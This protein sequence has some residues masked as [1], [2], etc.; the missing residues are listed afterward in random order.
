MCGLAGYL[1]LSNSQF[2]TQEHLLHAMAQALEHRGPNGYRVWTSAAHGIGLMYRRLSIVDLSQ[3]AFQPMFTHDGSVVVCCNGEIYNH[4]ALRKELEQLGYT[5]FS[6]SDIET[7]LYAYQEWGIDFLKR[8]E[9]MFSIVLLDIKKNEFYVVRDH[10]GIKPLYFSMQSDIFSFAS[11]IKALWHLPW[12]TKKIS[13]RSLSHYLTFLATPAPMTFFEGIYKLPAGFYAKIDAQR[14][15]TFCEWYTPLAATKI[16]QNMLTSE[17]ALIHELRSLL[18]A[19]IQKM[20]MADV[21]LGVFLSGGVDSSLNVALMA[22]FTDKVK[23]F[24]V[25]FADGPEYNE[26]H[27]AR[28]VAQLYNTEHHELIINE[29][30]AFGFFQK[31][32]FHQDEPLG[33]CVCVPLYFVSKLLKDAGVTVVQVGEGSDEL[34]CGYSSYIPYVTLEK[35]RALSQKVVPSFARQG[36]YQAAKMLVPHKHNRLDTLYNWATKKE[37]FWGGNVV[38]SE[39]WK[40]DFFYTHAQEIMY[41]DPVIAQIYP[42]FRQENSSHSPIAYH[43]HKLHSLNPEADFLKRMIYVELKHR[44]PELLLMRVDKMTMATSVEARVPFLDH[45][46]VEFAL[47]IPQHFKY[48]NGVTKYILKKAAEGILPNDIIYR[49]KMGFAAPTTRWFKQGTHFSTYFNDLLHSKSAQWEQFFDVDKIEKM[50]LQ[51]RTTNVDYSYQLWALQNFM[52]FY[53]NQ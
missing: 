42:D 32:I 18:R 29:A 23:T 38:F 41:I 26:A 7:L 36:V 52:G 46:L 30:D 10:I 11:E 35:S 2:T 31:M 1:N 16:P 43:A 27:W 53:A 28:K 15:V 45:A 37:F 13:S 51:T 17:Q 44:L 9:G 22:E 14:T 20:M 25:A 12:L 40:H 5:Y 6:Q 39:H 8:L 34:F 47:Q 24:N 49:N 21:P 48:K 33:D 19:S 4:P 50:A 3:A